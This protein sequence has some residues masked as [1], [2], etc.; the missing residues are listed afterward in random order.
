MP[1]SRF[2]FLSIPAQST[3]IVALLFLFSAV[4]LHPQV[5]PEQGAPPT[6]TQLQAREAINQG[7]QAFKN[8]QFQEAEQHFI[9]AN[10]LDPALLN[11]RLYLATAYAAQYIP[12]APSEE[13]IRTAK[14]A[15]DEYKDVLQTDAQNVPAIDGLAS[16]L[17]QRAGQ[18]FDAE[19][20]AES[21]SYHQKHIDL[22]PQ[23]PEPY[24][25]SGVIDWA[26][27]YRAN[28]E[29]RQEF[30]QSVRGEGLK[31]TDPL[32]E[33]L[34]KEY[35]QEYGAMVEEGIRFLNRAMELKPD[36]DDAMVYLNLLLRRKADMAATPTERETYTNQANELLDRVKELK[37]KRA[38]TPAQQNP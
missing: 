33:V 17:Y 8:G 10:E 20:F 18:P 23:D 27:A 37:Q 16:I 13:N 25:S 21:K 7:V 29:L 2:P 12:G 31:D 36:Y 24:Y 11:A 19:M 6:D 14:M 5:V 4:S 34:R 22:R 26:L 38:A 30:N 32:P 3:L 35:V 1:T 9:R 28:T 15:I